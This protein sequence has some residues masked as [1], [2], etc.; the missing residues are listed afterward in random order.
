MARHEALRTTFVMRDGE[1]MQ[2]I[3]AAAVG[4]ALTEHDLCGAREATAELGRLAAEEAS[5]PFNLAQGPLIRGRLVRLMEDEHVLLMTMHHIVSDGWSLGVLTRELSAL[6]AAFARGDQDPLA[7]LAVQYADYA[8]WQRQWLSGEVLQRQAAY[9]KEQLADAPALL[10]LPA[11]HARPAQADYAGASVEVRLDAPLTGALK[12]LSLRH[13]L[14]LHMTLLASFAA[15]LARLS[16][17]D[18]VVIGSPVANRARREIED[19]IGFFV[20]TLALRI[21]VSGTPSFAELLGRAKAVSLSAQ[22]HQDLPFEQ[23][24]EIVQPPRSLSHAA[25]FQAMLAWQNAPQGALELPGLTLLGLE[26]GAEAA[27]FDL[28]LSLGEAGNEIVGSLNYATTLFERATIAR[29][30]GYWVRLLEAMVADE[31]QAVERVALLG[32]EERHRLLVEWNATATDYPREQCI[33]ELFEAQVARTPDAVAVV[34]GDVALSYSEL[35]AR[36][37]RLAH[38]LIGLGVKPDDRVAICVERSVEMV[39][40][41]LAVLKA[42]GAYLPLDP[43][44]PAE[45]LAYMLADSAPKVVLADAAGRLALGDDAIAER[46]VVDL[47]AAMPMW[48]SLP[49]HDPD[50]RA[51]G[52]SSTNLAYVIYTSGSTGQPKGVGIAYSASVNFLHVMGPELGFGQHDMLLSL[53]PLSFDIAALE[54]F[55]PL[56]RG[57]RTVIASRLAATDPAQLVALIEQSG[58]SVMQATP[59]TWRMLTNHGWPVL[60]EPLRVLCGGEALPAGLA[61]QLLS[62]SPEVWNLYGPTE[63]TIWASTQRVWQDDGAI[64]IGRPIGNVQMY[65]LDGLL[66]LVPAGVAGELYIA[67]A[68]LGRSYLNRPDLTAE[69]FIADPFGAAGSR[70][71][72]TGDLARYLS[73][74]T[75]EYLGRLDEQVKLRGFRIELGEVEAALAS[76]EMVSDVVV[77]V[78]QDRENTPN[79]IA[80]VVPREASTAEHAPASVQTSFSLF[81]FGAE[82]YAQ[83]DKYA[84][85]LELARFADAH[86]FEAIW[87]PERH[88]HE[89]G[90]LYPNPSILNA[91]LSG[92]TKNV[93]LR[94]GSVVLPL[95][96]PLRV[97]EEWAVVDNLSGGRTGLAIASGWHPHDFAFFPERFADRRHFMYEGIE[98]IQ[99]LWS[100][101]AIARRNGTGRVCAGASLP[102]TVAAEIA[103]LAHGGR[104]PRD[105]RAGRPPRPEHP[106]SPFRAHA[107]RTGS[108]NRAIPSGASRGWARSGKRASHVDG[109]HLPWSGAGRDAR[110]CPWAV[111]ELHACACEPSAS[112]GEELGH[113]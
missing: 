55:L 110:A 2:R 72:R 96:D 103:H 50:P 107:Q 1:A 82:T 75:I 31:R 35:N 90:S 6:Y 77:S 7:P 34:F 23:V 66:N 80:Y 106:H 104:H 42:G 93:Q 17:Q 85:Y 74:G 8:V 87:T 41:L 52:L 14:T 71:Y 28:T 9:W 16:G 111:H 12:A 69:A 33:H 29:W 39:V 109:P 64:P 94:A 21:D 20:N 4:F 100:G 108:T 88:F 73:D 56:M 36:A 95:H 32:A 47:D 49:A 78:R 98:T 24:V 101:K 11:D 60:A 25:V 19:L 51:L 79:L 63:T 102:P 37:N 99:R 81:Y 113:Q 15:L 86:G 43:S 38:H 65:I 3:A 46:D 67:G 30:L 5:A 112:A 59:S 54:I 61:A 58:A 105:L 91:A 83:N 76:H 84:L 48:A 27:K 10:T 53:T 97:A 26:G 44:Y 13:G 40:A 62:H 57:A 45:R 70:M 89:V 68:G 92:I 18:E 22:E